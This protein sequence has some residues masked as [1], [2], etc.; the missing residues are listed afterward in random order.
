[1]TT[2]VTDL[3][4]GPAASSAANGAST[5][6]APSRGN[7]DRLIRFA[8]ANIARRPERFVLS[9]TGIGLA[10]M[11]VVVV[12][13]ISL[14]YA[15]SG[16]A[17][18]HDVLQGSPLW[19]VSQAGV[20]YDPQVEAILPTGPAPRVTVPEGWRAQRTVAGVW[21]SPAGRLALYGRSDVPDGV[22]EIGTS[23]AAKLSVATGDQ[24]TVGAAELVVAVAGSSASVKVAPEV[25]IAAVGDNGWWTF[26]P[27]AAVSHDRNLG[28]VL[29]AELG[30]PSSTD[31]AATPGPGDAGLVYDTVNGSGLVTF[32]QQFTALFAG[33]VNASA[34]GL[35][36][37]VGLALGFVIAVSSFL[38]AV[39]ER[40]RE[41]G[42]MSSIGLAD[43]VLYFF[44][45]E[46]AIVFLAAYLAGV[47]LSGVA[48]AVVVP[49]MT[50][51]AN[52][53]QAAG[54]VAGYL[55]A[56]AIVGALVPV[57][58]LL[59]QRPVSLLEDPA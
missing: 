22:A 52:W 54:N 29:G 39:Q 43:E 53:L 37:T 26:S 38:A 28:E 4:S 36:S 15:A 6:T 7:S 47:L 46:S 3:R 51:L 55:P 17:S 5:S 1:M 45:V 12:R 44:L 14:G 32:E 10:V 20:H 11:A 27:P 2:T 42:I 49:D 57:H 30:L 25:A 13:T 35:V 58:R 34:L 8:C 48:V 23:A 16:S 41:F 18:L 59:Q 21:S 56:M 31:P 40:R 50:G 33:K 9:V 19:V 24:I